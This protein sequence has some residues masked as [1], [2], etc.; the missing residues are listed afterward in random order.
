MHAIHMEALQGKNAHLSAQI[1][2][3]G[4]KTDITGRKILNIPYTIWQL[5]THINHW[6]D[7]WLARLNGIDQVCDLL[8]SGSQISIQADEKYSSYHD[9]V[10]AMASHLSYH[11]GKLIILRRIFG[12]WPPPSGGFVW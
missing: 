11:I 1:A 12:A 5:I 10:Q 7:K 9:V 8:E 6:K 3:E 4:L 2:L